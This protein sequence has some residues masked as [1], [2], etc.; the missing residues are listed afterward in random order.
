[1]NNIEFYNKYL[2]K[3]IFEIEN[4]MGNILPGYPAKV[5]FRVLGAKKYLSGGNN[6]EFL[7]YEIIILP[8]G[9]FNRLVDILFQND[10]EMIIT[11]TSMD[12]YALRMKCN[13]SLQYFLSLLGED[14][15]VMCVLMKN[16]YNNT[17][18]ESV[19]NESKHDTMVS[20]LVKVILEQLKLF[21]NSD[22]K[23]AQIDLP[24]EGE[25]YQTPFIK[26]ESFPFYIELYLFKTNLQ[27]YKID[28]DAPSEFEDNDIRVGIYYNPKLLKSQISEIKNNLIYTLR[29]EYEHLL[30]VISDYERV[31]YQKKH[32]YKKDSLST[33]LK[34]QEIEPQVRGYYLQSK[35]EKKPFD[36]I[37]SNHL[38]KME[39]NGQ[40]SFI[41]PDRKKI[42][43]DILVDYAKKMN[44]PIKLSSL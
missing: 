31:S 30:Q 15:P 16:V 18:N 3:K 1:M 37:I 32:R 36:L 9:T 21:N 42:V 39:K 28:A 22:L 43:I 25:Y 11:T 8:S 24:E 12:F 40:I 38:D 19:I 29:H 7:T 34:Q 44:L 13:E 41:G 10:N 4:P 20:N 17:M 35:K 27:H 2:D 23:E 14:R 33:L 5:K 6:I 26:G